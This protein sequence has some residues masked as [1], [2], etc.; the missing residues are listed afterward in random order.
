AS[1]ERNP[2]PAAAM[3]ADPENKL[4]WHARLKRRDAESVRDVMLQAAG[5]LELRMYGPS[6]HPELPAPLMESRY[7]WD[8]DPRPAARAPRPP[9]PRRRPPLRLRPGPAEQAVPPPGRLR[10]AGPDQ[11]LPDPGHHDHGPAGAGDAQQQLHRRPGP[12][13]GRPAAGRTRGRPRPG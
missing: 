11:Q 9:P 7:S 8:P 13:A 4:L 12:A 2:A 10:R 3:K 1:P 6:A 5:R